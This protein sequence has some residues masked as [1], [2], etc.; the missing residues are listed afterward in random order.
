MEYEYHHVFAFTHSIKF[1]YATPSSRSGYTFHFLLILF[2]FSE[3]A[4]IFKTV[5]H[6][7]TRHA[8]NQF[9]R[10]AVVSRWWLS[11]PPE[12]IS[13]ILLLLDVK[14]FHHFRDTSHQLRCIASGIPQYRH[15]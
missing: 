4:I 9:R 13:D 12:V 3:I 15:E 11:Q 1:N 8:M 2:D 6:K 5:R 7:P 10:M 14:S